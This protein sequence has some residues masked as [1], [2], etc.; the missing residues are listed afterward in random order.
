MVRSSELSGGNP[1]AEGDQA[2]K[3]LADR[4][5]SAV[6]RPDANRVPSDIG[7]DEVD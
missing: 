3:D 1:F 5:L 6:E 2:I 4:A 7:I